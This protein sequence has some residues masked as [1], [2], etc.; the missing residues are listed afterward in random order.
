MHGVNPPP[1]APRGRLLVGSPRARRGLRPASPPSPPPLCREGRR[2]LGLSWIAPAPRA[3][4]FA[5]TFGCPACT[6]SGMDAPLELRRRATNV[7]SNFHIL[8]NKRTHVNMPVLLSGPYSQPNKDKKKK[9]E[10]TKRL[11]RTT[12]S[13]ESQRPAHAEPAKSLAS[14]RPR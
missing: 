7:C 12:R 9:V 8:C 5:E 13:H 3:P 6:E 10:V 1:L 2:C 11:E 4:D 14:D